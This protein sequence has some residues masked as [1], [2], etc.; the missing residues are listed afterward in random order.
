MPVHT[1]RQAAPPDVARIRAIVTAAYAKYL[2]RMDRPPAPLLADYPAAV[3]R[4][5][6]WVAVTDGAVTGLVVVRVMPDHLLLENVAV[7]PSVQRTGVGARLLDLAEEQAARAGLT[8]IRLYTNAAMTENLA[9]Y[10]RHGY[11]ET[12]RGERNGYQLVYFS[13]QLRAAG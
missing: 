8:E 3:A 12:H 7:D 9:Y 1:V 5:E 13:K 6:V 4:G 10:P 2:P 11:V